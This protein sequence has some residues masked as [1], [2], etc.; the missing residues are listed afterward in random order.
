MVTNPDDKEAEDGG[1][2]RHC[3]ECS[4]S[5]PATAKLCYHCDTFQDFRRYLAFSTTS[6]ALITAFF[7]VTALAAPVIVEL[8]HKPRS[9]AYLIN[10]SVEGTTLRIVAVNQGDMAATLSQVEMTGTMLA[11]ATKIRLRNDEAAL[12][13]P[14]SKLLIFDIVPL[15]SQEQS[16]SQ[17]LELLSQV[18]DRPENV[19]TSLTFTIYQSDG[20]SLLQR[21]ELGWRDIFS[22]L[23]WN[24]D[25]CSAIPEPN[26]ENGC[27]GPGEGTELP[28]SPNDPE[29]AD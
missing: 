12:L 28:W 21:F 1:P 7:S 11:P 24:A 9:H 10:P 15:L 27:V 22:I 20:T 25:R 4:Q 16:Y 29:H 26:F 6:L 14:G 3:V 23:R 13:N 19:N 18:N 8:L 2:T 17:S 5:I